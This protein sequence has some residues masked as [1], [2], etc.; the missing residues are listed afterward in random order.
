M[1]QYLVMT[2]AFWG[3]EYVH[4]EIVIVFVFTPNR[5]TDKQ[6]PDSQGEKWGNRQNYL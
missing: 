5:H 1:G 4:A 6:A 3:V 2:G